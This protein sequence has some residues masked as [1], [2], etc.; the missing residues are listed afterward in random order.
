[1]AKMEIAFKLF[2]NVQSTRTQVLQ[3][4]LATLPPKTKKTRQIVLKLKNSTRF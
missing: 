3:V 2:W 1:M 4:L